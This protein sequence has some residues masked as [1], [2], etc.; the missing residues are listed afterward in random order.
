MID[1]RT[2]SLA[3][4]VNTGDRPIG[5]LA[6]DFLEVVVDMQARGHNNYRRVSLSGCKPTI[7][8]VGADGAAREMAFFASNDYLNLTQHPRTKAAGI[9]AVE[10]Y[11]SGAGSVP[12]LGGTLDL[13]IELEQKV[14]AFK[15]CED[16]ILFSNGFGSNCG[17]LQALLGENGCA[18]C[19]VL[20]HASLLDGC[21]NSQLEFFRH[22]DMDSLEFALAK[23]AKKSKNIIVICD[24]VYSMDG[25]IAPLDQICDRAHAA[26]A[27]VLVDEAHATGVIGANG[28]GTPE[29]FGLEGKVDLV[30]GTFSKAI[31]SV[32]GF[33]ASNKAII[34][35]LRYYARSYMFSTAITPQATASISA[36]LDVIQDEPQLREALWHNINRF[37]DGLI[38]MGVDFGNAQTAIFP[39]ITGDDLKVREMCRECHEHGI[40]VNPVVYPAVQRRLAR[41]RFSLM[42]NHTDEQLDDALN[43]LEYLNGKYQFVKAKK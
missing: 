16:A 40:Y 43:F 4:Y 7:T 30:A 10:K 32:G 20:V 24:G 5:Q 39:I 8:M 34:N 12:L 15:G 25:D 33:I 22:S 21:K 6:E 2:K 31:G 14:A 1:S 26:G 13:H 11:G 37:R 3:D 9:A 29:H 18:V 42:C 23:A 19:D 35:Y 38:A 41:L 27:L 36:S 17:S 28:R